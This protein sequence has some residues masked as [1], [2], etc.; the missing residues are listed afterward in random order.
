MTLDHVTVSG[1]TSDD[2]GGGLL[3]FRAA[4]TLEIVDSTIS[5]N[6]AHGS[7]GGGGI[8]VVGGSSSLSRVSITGNS[9]D[10]GTLGG[11]GATFFSAGNHSV[12][13]STISTN[14]S[15]M[16]GGGIYR[17]FSG[18][19]TLTGSTVSGNSSTLDGGGIG[20]FGSG[21][22]EATDVNI[23]N[24]TSATLGGGISGAGI[25]TTA[26]TRVTVANNTAT[27]DS[28]G[29]M[30]SSRPT[31]IDSSTIS[32]NTAGTYGGG[33]ALVVASAMTVANSTVAG[34]TAGTSGGGAFSDTNLVLEHSTV[35]DNSAASSSDSSG[36][37]IQADGRLIID[38]SVITHGVGRTGQDCLIY[39]AVTDKGLSGVDS[40]GTC[41]V[42][43][44][45]ADPKLGPLQ[46]NG[47]AT[48]TRALLEGSPLID[49]L[50]ADTGPCPSVGIDQRGVARPQHEKC[51]IGAVEDQWG[52]IAPS[53]EQVPYGSLSPK[54]PVLTA[55]GLASAPGYTKPSC[56]ATSYTPTSP[57]ASYPVTCWGG[58]AGGWVVE[59]RPGTLTVVKADQPAPTVTSLAGVAGKATALAATG[60]LGTGGYSFT[61]AST[62]SARCTLGGTPGAQTVTAAASGSCGIQVVRAGD[63]NHNASPASSVA[64]V[65][66]T[67]KP[68]APRSPVGSPRSR[69]AV[70]SW[71]APRSTGGAAITGYRVT[72]TTKVGISYPY[73]TASKKQRSCTV[74]GLVN[75]RAY[76]FRVNAT[77]AVG[78][79]LP[80]AASLSVVAGAPS[81]PR[82]L[83]V[84]LPAAG[85]AKVAWTAPQFIG[86]GA[87]TGYRV[88]WCKVSGSCAAWAS[89]P[90]TAR[91]ATAT[92]RV[93]NTNYRVEIQAKN[94]SG[95][96]PTAS[97][98]FKQAK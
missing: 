28:G 6:A 66:V 81:N 82:K 83:A 86:S 11:G 40:D 51:D 10:G 72:S 63:G 30:H 35:A 29:G 84:T 54:F 36:V 43:S 77:N 18:R 75:G 24:N 55:T 25:G 4:A 70:V 22:F 93:K 31:S 20:A 91:S 47:G 38:A 3:Q 89:L 45:F 46:D 8:A 76:S 80:S 96:G 74:K 16:R 42:A 53:D 14:T 23:V 64:T 32:G 60:G 17:G 56:A 98:V 50:A 90:K 92:A 5:N 44:T 65:V 97:K 34:N 2:A 95:Y 78:P 58:G 26:L 62:G 9:A 15:T 67:S 41:G 39:G 21:A 7:S 79:S 88:R 71:T 49:V 12:T 57:V 68:S 48:F 37:Q 1:N 13:D 87:I 85:R 19:L 94:G 69:A 33:L 59:Y 73:C 61:L 52:W 27:T